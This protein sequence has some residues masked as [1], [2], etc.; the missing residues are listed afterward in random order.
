MTLR[1][2][3][4]TAMAMA[5][6]LAA[7]EPKDDWTR[8]QLHLTPRTGWA[9]DPN[10]LVWRDGEWHFFH[11]HNPND[12]KWGPMHWNHLVSTDLLHWTELGD[13]LKP[14]A[15]GTMFSGSA[16]VDRAN[17]A[18]FGENA[19]VLLY[20]AAGDQVTPKLPFTQ[21]LAHST[22]GRAF[23]KFAG[24][25]V[26]PCIAEGGNRDPKVFW[27]EPSRQWVMA[28]YGQR[29]G[30]HA[31]IVLNSPDLKRWTEVSTYVGDVVKAGKWLY[32]CP[33]LEEIG[34]EGERASAWVVW[35]AADA[36]AVGAF[37]GRRFTP[38]EER[39]P[40]LA[41][42]PGQ[43]PFYAA[44][45]FANVPDGR[46]LWVAWFRLPRS[47]EAAY[48]HAFSLIEELTLRRTPEGLRLVRRPARELAQLREG[49]ALP[50]ERFDGELAEIHLACRVPP[51]E[52]AEFDLRGVR[53]AY[54]GT[55]RT[56]TAAGT[57]VPWSC[58]ND[59][60]ALTVYL[61]RIGMEIFSDDGLKVM[62]VAAARPD[63]A[64]RGLSART[65]PGVTDRRFTAWRLRS[66]WEN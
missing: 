36:Y 18:G 63:R 32:E 13:A 5:T 58:V 64:K 14:D 9:N 47:P 52:T 50:L 45:T 55:A 59:E 30:R 38:E 8:P 7:V 65:S 26:L 28:L 60:L 56:L 35:G 20:T 24:N 23:A 51:G 27:H 19:I 61:D 57:T 34:I 6:A 17:S 41:L 10:G 62:P 49:D 15:L 21:C 25:P 54:D 44:Q 11:Q 40:G 3:A 4:M 16:V 29:N 46:T 37:D 66:I 31:V 53:L 43:M 1:L 2:T 33:G 42:A 12:V 22:D 48:T 39:L